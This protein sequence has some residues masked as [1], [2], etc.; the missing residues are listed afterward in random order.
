MAK[1]VDSK[2][3][4][5]AEMLKVW[6][7]EG[8]SLLKSKNNAHFDKV[9]TS[10]KIWQPGLGLLILS[11]HGKEIYLSGNYEICQLF[12]KDNNIEQF[13]NQGVQVVQFH[14]GLIIIAKQKNHTRII[15]VHHDT[16]INILR[17]F[18][19][20][21]EL[22]NSE[23]Q[24]LMQ[25]LCG[26]TL[27][28]ASKADNVSYETKRTQFKSLA[29]RTG[30]RSQS[31][32]IRNI[33]LSL[34]SFAL[35]ISEEFPLANNKS[36]NT[37]LFLDKYYPDIFRFHQINSLNGHK[38]NIAETGPYDGKPIIW[39]H[40]QTLPCPS[41]FSNDW[42]NKQKLRFIIPFREGFLS[43]VE[44]YYSRQ[45]HL[46]R[47]T[48]DIA[49]II[50]I[51]CNGSADII[52]NSSGTAFAINLALKYADHV[53][54]L[55]ICAAAYVGKYETQSVRRMVHGIKNLTLKNENLAAK[56]VDNYIVKMSSPI[57]AM[58]VLKSA[59][60]NSQIDIKI[61]KELLSNPKNHAWLY[62]SYKLSRYSVIKDI[63]MAGDNIWQ[64]AKQI[65]C[66][67]LFIHGKHDPINS[68][69]AAQKA[70]KLIADSKFI[71]LENQGQSLFISCLADL[72][73]KS[74][75]H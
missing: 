60:K 21:V 52:A 47:C 54:K 44:H 5:D 6:Y 29:A 26:K 63:A 24:L 45:V 9:L 67:T 39:L 65:N 7:E 22:T 19:P 57:G 73:A 70:S 30:F 71:A 35:G 59:Y 37:R 46:E 68:F 10:P 25:I 75:S 42:P 36:E 23:F 72:V 62:E 50:E 13:G 3:S 53:N 41:Q 48:E 17:Q 34:S 66:P 11:N 28:E 38:I 18:T 74:L 16:L 40:S 2:D 49:T 56:V 1:R 61:F 69:K 15:F 27:K 4:S 32:L 58:E 64:N 8:L 51:F 20:Q 55:T 14:N 12:A 31:E 33:L 43:E